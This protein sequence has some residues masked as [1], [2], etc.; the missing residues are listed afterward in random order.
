MRQVSL[1]LTEDKIRAIR[2]S[3]PNTLADIKKSICP[4]CNSKHEQECCTKFCPT[5]AKEFQ[6][7]VAPKQAKMME[8]LV[9]EF[10]GE[11]RR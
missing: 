7:W 11:T 9:Q 5:C 8:K 4:R 10:I 6:K 1:D 2:A 3:H